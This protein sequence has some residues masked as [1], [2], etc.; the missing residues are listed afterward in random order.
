MYNIR[1]QLGNTI[2]IN[3][4]RLR[5]LFPLVFSA[6]NGLLS[7]YN[8]NII[9]NPDGS[10][11]ID[12]NADKPF[13][14]KQ[15]AVPEKKNIFRESLQKGTPTLQEQKDFSQDFNERQQPDILHDKSEEEHSIN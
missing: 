9:Q 6:K 1:F 7:K 15:Q 4:S 13:I 3:D 12:Y 2:D 5:E 11:S 8:Y 10:L 14:D